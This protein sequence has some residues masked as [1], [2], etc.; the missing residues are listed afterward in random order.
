MRSTHSLI[1]VGAVAL[2]ML[3]VVTSWHGPARTVAGI[4]YS[5]QQPQ[6]V[7]DGDAQ[8][9]ILDSALAAYREARFEVALAQLT[10][11][12]ALDRAEQQEPLPELLLNA[13]LCSLRLLRS[14]DAEDHVAP[15]AVDGSEWAAD[16]AFLL[17]L[18]SCQHAERAV[19]AA[20]LVDAEPMAWAM[21]ARAIQGAQLQFSRVCELRPD[22]PE[23]V[24]NLERTVRRR[25]A[26]EGERDAHKPKDAKKEDAPDQLPPPPEKPREP[27]EEVIIPEMAIAPL[28]PGEL[29]RL[30][31]RLQERQQLKLRGRQQRVRGGSTASGRDW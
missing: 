6:I 15:L 27:E 30:R 9:E 7:R 21:A 29:Q 13:A 24:R 22:W 16:A 1:G 26:I 2:L 12:I 5:W 18:A 8:L 17:G 20:R 10:E 11:R 28:Q 4:G 14:R 3:L 19:T 23:A 31:K 25:Q